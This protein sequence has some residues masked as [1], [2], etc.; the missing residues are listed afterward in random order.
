M[1]IPRRLPDR[2]L[3][4]DGDEHERYHLSHR[5]DRGD[6]GH[7]VLLRPALRAFKMTIVSD[8][9]RVVGRPR[10][11]WP[12]IFAGAFAAAALATVLHS[13]AAA[14]GLAVSST[15]PTWRDSSVAL[16]ILT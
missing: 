8:E 14:I 2:T 11:H 12:A 7:P 13:F 1:P 5:P 3:V 16:W 4:S 15:A 6:H 10:I 9:T